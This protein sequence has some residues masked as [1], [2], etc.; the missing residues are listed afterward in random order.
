MTFKIL[1]WNCRG[2]KS[3]LFHFHLKELLCI[4]K[5][6]ELALLETKVNSAYVLSKIYKYS[7]FNKSV[8]AEARGFMGGIWLL[9]DDTQISLEVASIDD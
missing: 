9:W 8:C 2:A 5:P 4:H 7:T 3:P 6:S 1:S